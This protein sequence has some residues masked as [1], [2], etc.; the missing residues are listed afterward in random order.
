MLQLQPP[1]LSAVVDTRLGSCGCSIICN[2]QDGGRQ[3]ADLGSRNKEEQTR[4]TKTS[5]EDEQ[6]TGIN[7]R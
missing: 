6:R 4:V 7:A 2:L 1:V 5:E 3:Q